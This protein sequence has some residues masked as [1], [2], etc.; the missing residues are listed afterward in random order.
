MRANRARVMEDMSLTSGNR[1]SPIQKAAITLYMIA[2]TMCDWM[3]RG[4]S[5]DLYPLELWREKP[6]EPTRLLRAVINRIQTTIP[7]ECLR[8]GM[9]FS[10]GWWASVPVPALG[11]GF[12]ALGTDGL[13]HLVCGLLSVV[14]CLLSVVW[15]LVHLV[16]AVTLRNTQPRKRQN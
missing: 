1:G 12:G 7:W 6:K 15:G 13:G 14:C 8:C 4:Y 16:W 9:A 5:S 10:V 2:N 3:Y 11:C